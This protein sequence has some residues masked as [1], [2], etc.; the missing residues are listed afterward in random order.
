MA[1][2][3]RIEGRQV[4]LRSITA[5]DIPWLWHQMYGDPEAEWRKYDAPFLDHPTV[6]FEE[7]EARVLRL[8]G[9]GKPLSRLM[10]ERQGRPIGTVSYYYEDGATQNW[11]E[12]GVLIF[13]PA[14]WNGGLGTE[15]LALWTDHLFA[16]LPLVRV[17]ITTWSG[18]PR[19]MRAAE[20]TGFTLEG[21]LRRVRYWQG[22]HYDSIRMGVLR[23]EWEQ[24]KSRHPNG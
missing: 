23:E 15:A 7:Y 9:S 5:D 11:L 24:M 22:Q 3:I 18:N 1:E 21:R 6:P 10:I 19:M 2:P 12:A 8:L 14:Y 16:T 20:K 4:S 13:D 17:G